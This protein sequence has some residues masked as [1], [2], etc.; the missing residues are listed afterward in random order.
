MRR[1]EFITLLSGT[2]VAWPIAASAQQSDSG[3]GSSWG[4]RTRASESRHVECIPRR[5][6]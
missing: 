1:R 4:G 5:D 2:V 3:A 6:A